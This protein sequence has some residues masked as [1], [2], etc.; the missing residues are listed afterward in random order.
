MQVK[1]RATIFVARRGVH[2]R[3]SGQF[4]P[5][6]NDRDQQ[7]LSSKIQFEWYVAGEFLLSVLQRFARFARHRS[8]APNGQA[9]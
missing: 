3:D 6:S 7:I 4:L 8:N 9:Q 1:R 2:C 5:W